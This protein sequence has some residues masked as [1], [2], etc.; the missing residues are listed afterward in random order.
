MWLCGLG[1]TH[2]L[3]GVLF[4][5]GRSAGGRR[6]LGRG[7][8]RLLESRLTGRRW[9]LAARLGERRRRCGLRGG[10]RRRVVGGLDRRQAAGVPP[11]CRELRRGAG[12]AR[13]LA[14]GLGGGRRAAGGR[15]WRQAGWVLRCSWRT[16]A[17]GVAGRRVS[18]F[19][20][21]WSRFF[22]SCAKE[23]HLSGS[24]ALGMANTPW[25]RVPSLTSPCK[26]GEIRTCPHSQPH[27]SQ[28]HPPP[29]SSSPNPTVSA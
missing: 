11:R 17:P 26:P 29:W 28:G 2:R 8:G 12:L 22:N 21:C 4:S 6:S 16:L 1:V 5:E 27:V 15:L 23:K 19:R 13:G 10:L 20:G 7:V 3:A 18:W 9:A 25:P 14:R 24:G